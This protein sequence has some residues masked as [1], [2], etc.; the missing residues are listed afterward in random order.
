MK[1]IRPEMIELT[2]KKSAGFCAS[3]SG[4][5]L[6]SSFNVCGTGTS[7]DNVI[8]TNGAGDGHDFWQC[9]GGSSPIYLIDA[10]S[11]GNGD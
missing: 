10:C 4:A 1:Y 2:A 8:C 11:T 3:G 5:T 6:G 7:V 9:A